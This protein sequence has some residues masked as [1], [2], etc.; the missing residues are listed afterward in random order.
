MTKF[1]EPVWVGM[2]VDAELARF[3][4][5]DQQ[6]AAAVRGGRAV[7][8]ASRRSL[9]GSGLRASLALTGKEAL[10]PQSP[11]AA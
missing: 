5:E 8:G 3:E 7:K 11:L 4:R 6:R 9:L 1:R 2:D 10:L